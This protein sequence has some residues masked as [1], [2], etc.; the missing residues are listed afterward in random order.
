MQTLKGAATCT[1]VCL[2][3]WREMRCCSPLPSPRRTE[4]QMSEGQ[5]GSCCCFVVL[6][7]LR[8]WNYMIIR[9]QPTLFPLRTPKEGGKPLTI[10]KRHFFS[11]PRKY[12]FICFD[13][14][15]FFPLRILCAIHECTYTHTHRR[16]HSLKIYSSAIS[17]TKDKSSV[18]ISIIFSSKGSLTGVVPH[19]LANI[20]FRQLI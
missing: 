10:S 8:R 17:Y 5:R 13:L 2:Q 18:H 4:K 9:N 3:S 16:K 12:K 19:H 7:C 20:S 11:L 6:F 14:I 15:F 1:A